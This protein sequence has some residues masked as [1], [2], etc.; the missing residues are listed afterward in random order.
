MFTCVAYRWVRSHSVNV[1]H[2]PF[3]DDSVICQSALGN[4]KITCGRTHFDLFY[5]RRMTLYEIRLL[6][7]ILIQFTLSYIVEYCIWKT[8]KFSEIVSVAL[9][10]NYRLSAHAEA[11]G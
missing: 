7:F 6:Y 3:E 10:D 1:N 9:P 4:L 8:R 11:R 5:L 2:K